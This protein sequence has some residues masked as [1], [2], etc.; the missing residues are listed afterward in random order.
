MNDQ[1]HSITDWLIPVAAAA[2]DSQPAAEGVPATNSAETH[3]TTAV[4]D[5]HAEEGGIAAGLKAIGLDGKLLIA[6]I[7]NFVILLLLLRR[8]LY[9]PLVGLLEQRRE[10][11]EKSQKQAAEIEKR[12]ADF[13]IEHQQRIEESKQ[14]A[15]ALVAKAKEAA[16]SL[17]Q[18]TLKSTQAEAEKLLT[19]ANQEISSQKEKMLKEAKSEIGQLVIAAT[20]KILGQTMTK[21]TQE[22]LL[23]E[24]LEGAKK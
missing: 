8:F 5:T 17:R 12:F 20:E 21:D 16:E 14:E 3:A 23:K 1:Q 24:A 4:S 13:Q 18:E 15:V 19:R 22:K 6:Q 7:I 11:I 9:K 2:T 10:T